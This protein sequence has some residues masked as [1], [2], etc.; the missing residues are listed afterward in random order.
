[1]EA[2]SR[3][4]SI[5]SFGKPASLSSSAKSRKR[6][7]RLQAQQIPPPRKPFRWRFAI[8]IV[9]G[10]FG[11]AGGLYLARP[12]LERFRASRK[13]AA[14]RS[15][16]AAGHVDEARAAQIE[17]LLL[18]PH[19]AEARTALAELELAQNRLE[20]AFLQFQMLTELQP[21]NPAPWLGLSRVRMA[22]GQPEE[23]EA[24]IGRALELGGGDESTWL[25]RSQ[26][27][28][29]F[30]RFHGAMLDARHAAQLSPQDA[31]AQLALSLATSRV[32]GKPA[33]DGAPSSPRHASLDR[34]DA[35]PGRLG[36]AMREL[37]TKMGSKD[38][39][40]A[41]EIAASAR[42]DYPATMLGPWLDGLIAFGRGDPDAAERDYREALRVS[43][44]SHRAL[45]N[46]IPI[47]SRKGGSIGLGD[48]LAAAAEADFGFIY[49]LKIAAR[50]YLEGDQPARAEAAL[51]RAFEMQPG[52]PE[53]FRDLAEFDLEI[54][55]ASD[56]IVICDRGL[57]RFPHDAALDLDAARAAA[58]LGDRT[59]AAESYEAGLRE[60]PDD[61]PAAAELAAL[62]VEGSH[63]QIDRAV[64]LVRGLE[65]DAPLD[66]Q[67][68]GAMGLVYLRAKL[69]GQRAQQLLEFASGA[70]PDDLQ[71]HYQLA[72]A[73][74]SNQN[75]ARAA[76]ELR[77]ALEPA[78]SFPGEAEARRLL[79]ELTGSR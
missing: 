72:L 10:A 40:A 7:R 63:S 27:R 46:L 15:E 3:R 56:A 58:S 67:V 12:V 41:S 44:R 33:P 55:R 17:T 65:R 26:L 74:S 75:K 4:A 20:Q 34:A 24:A 69:D 14:A 62:L 32:E 25:L 42:R 71:L 47:W 37:L 5:G 76:D 73:Y 11:I 2:L 36:P 79:R 22:A 57:A 60:R 78:R 64:E 18:E 52:S 49:P 23:A 35:W 29:G 70:A 68:L 6:E 30:G 38:F 28:Y 66:P 16:L 48:Q 50:S 51:R 1:M 19:D 9:A 43:P 53:P 54:D 77:R 13:L 45:T 59:R 8:A 21:E 31:A 61:Q 39:G